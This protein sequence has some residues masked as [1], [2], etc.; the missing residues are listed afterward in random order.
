[1]RGRA[2][3]ALTLADRL[4]NEIPYERDA[5]LAGWLLM[6]RALV[7]GLAGDREGALDDLEAGFSTPHS[8]PIT[9]W[10]LALDPNWDFMR[11]DPRFQA[12]ATPAPESP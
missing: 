1:M 9:A 12:F 4:V 10:D 7:R 5:L 3:E 6:N 2:D 11:D 8:L